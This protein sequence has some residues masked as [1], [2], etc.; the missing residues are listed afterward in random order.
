MSFILY[1]RQQTKL[2]E[3]NAFIGVYLSTGGV[4]YLKYIM[5]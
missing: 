1:Y 4:V 5:G 2:R 3:G